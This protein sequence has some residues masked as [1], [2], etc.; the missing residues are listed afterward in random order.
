VQPKK[1]NLDLGICYLTSTIRK[2]CNWYAFSS[3]G[4]KA[5]PTSHTPYTLHAH[6][7]N[8]SKLLLLL[9]YQTIFQHITPTMA[10]SAMCGNKYF[11]QIHIA[12][13]KTKN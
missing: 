9:A 7:I 12:Q 2:L 13:R 11:K 6:L 5:Q 8:L 4:V 3:I 10:I 1:G